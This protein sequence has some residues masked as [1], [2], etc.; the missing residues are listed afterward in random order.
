M[1]LPV[2]PPMASYIPWKHRQNASHHPI[3]FVASQAKIADFGTVMLTD[4]QTIRKIFSAGY[5]ARGGYAIA[6]KL[7]PMNVSSRIYKSCMPHRKT[8]SIC[9]VVSNKEQWFWY[10]FLPTYIHIQTY[11]Y[12]YI[13]IHTYTYIHIHTY[14][15]IHT[16]IHTHTYIRIRIRIRIRRHMHI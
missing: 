15:Y 14:T 10:V 5:A 2:P 8:T 11:T 3:I 13:H 16:D 4:V 12:I 7:G 1:F 9:C 6:P